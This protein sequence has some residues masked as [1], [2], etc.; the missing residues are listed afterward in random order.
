MSRYYDMLRRY[1]TDLP[2]LPPNT[3][4]DDWR[5]DDPDAFF[6]PIARRNAWS[7]IEPE[8]FRGTLLR[9]YKRL[10]YEAKRNVQRAE[11]ER[12]AALRGPPTNCRR[13]GNVVRWDPPDLDGGETPECYW[14]EQERNGEW[15]TLQPPVYHYEPREKALLG[16]GPARVAAYYPNEPQRLGLGWGYR[17]GPLLERPAETPERM[18]RI[19]EAC[20]TY[21]GPRLRRGG[22]PYVVHLRRHA[23]MPGISSAERHQA[24]RTATRRT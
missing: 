13:E 8:R 12:R 19:V 22:A 14:I 6:E 16:D 18:A 23:G 17:R 15:T 11:D 5:P 2:E 21:T 3:I 9:I 4:D 20:R 24:H 1:F 10:Q 7:K